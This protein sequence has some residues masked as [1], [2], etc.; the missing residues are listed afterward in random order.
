[1]PGAEH[2]ALHIEATR[3]TA[4]HRGI[5]SE[6]TSTIFP[7]KIVSS[8]HQRCEGFV[9]QQGAHIT[10]RHGSSQF[11]VAVPIDLF[12]G[13]RQLLDDVRGDDAVAVE[14]ALSKHQQFSLPR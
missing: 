5:S 6:Q 10:G 14:S 9:G 3:R 8:V 11:H 2:R 12:S 7:P 4:Q 1:M 13:D